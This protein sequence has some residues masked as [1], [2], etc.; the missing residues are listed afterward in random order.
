LG[1]LP[2]RSAEINF[3]V[4]SPNAGRTTD[5]KWIRVLMAL[6]KAWIKQFSYQTK[7]GHGSWRER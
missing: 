6:G 2:V 7:Y 1:E 5:M 3:D 4:D